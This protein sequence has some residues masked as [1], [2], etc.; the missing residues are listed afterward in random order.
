M[1]SP[2]ASIV[3]KTYESFAKDDIPLVFEAFD[4]SITWNVP[5]HSLISGDYRGRDEIVAFFKHTVELCG[6]VFAIEVHHVLS[7]EDVVVA[8]VTVRRNETVAPLHSRR[9]MC[10]A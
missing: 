3:C 10:G 4:P 8:L 5:G 2:N 9:C 7:E 6:R 1:I